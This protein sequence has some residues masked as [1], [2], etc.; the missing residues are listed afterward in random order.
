[1]KH[2]TDALVTVAQIGGRLEPVGDQ[3]RALLPRGC[4]DDLR[5]G[6]RQH[7]SQL[8]ALLRHKFLIIDS[9]VL[10]ETLFFV[11]DDQAKAAL[12]KAGAG[13]GCIY[14]RDELRLLVEKNRGEPIT[15]ADLLSI[16]AA[17]RVFN[18]RIASLLL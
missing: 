11:A 13:P 12:A 10:D 7:K 9:V 14:T 17:K 18:G 16:H 15:A 3:L 6:L 8:L 1:M 4:P 5:N 2:A